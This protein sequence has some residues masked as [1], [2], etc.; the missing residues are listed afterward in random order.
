M[1]FGFNVECQA[2][3]HTLWE[4]F[5]GPVFA[6]ASA[7]ANSS[8]TANTTVTIIPRLRSLKKHQKGY[9]KEDLTQYLLLGS[10]PQGFYNTY[11]LKSVV[12]AL[13]KWKYTPGKRDFPRSR[14]VNEIVPPG[15]LGIRTDDNQNPV[16]ETI[17]SKPSIRIA[18]NWPRIRS[19]NAV[20]GGVSANEVSAICL[21]AI[22]TRLI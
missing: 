1:G 17:I 14:P 8:P 22:E 9:Q 6:E 21:S 3:V 19:Q 15:L 12:D 4:S 16:A 11:I 18:G 5:M 20:M 7:S 10:H 2:V 13:V